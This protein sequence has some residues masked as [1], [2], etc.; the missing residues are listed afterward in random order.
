M[1]HCFES[2]QPPWVHESMITYNISW[3]YILLSLLVDCSRL[4]MYKLVSYGTS[5][6]L[7][8]T[9]NY[10]THYPTLRLTVIVS[11]TND[12][13]HT[14]YCYWMFLVSY[15]FM[16]LFVY[17]VHWLIS[18]PSFDDHTIGIV[19][20]YHNHWLPIMVTSCSFIGWYVFP[21]VENGCLVGGFNPKL[22]NMLVTQPTVC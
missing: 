8:F 10:P 19:V 9:P 3:D 21:L 12:N 5:P 17:I 2:H 22:Q 4:H 16:L 18:I 11:N 13:N 15:Q 6:L 14:S 7:P 1:N 20:H